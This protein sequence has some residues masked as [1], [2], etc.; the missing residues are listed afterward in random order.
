LKLTS[1]AGRL[2][3]APLLLFGSCRHSDGA[4]AR[5]TTAQLARAVEMLRLSS[6]HDKRLWLNRLRTLPCEGDDACQLQSVCVHAYDEHT[7][8]IDMIETAGHQLE[9]P[10][11]ADF[12]GPDA[13]AE[14]LLQTAA[15]AQRAQ[16]LLGQARRLTRNC[17]ENEAIIRERY[18]LR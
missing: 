2:W 1:G 12:G 4:E 11:D 18:R 3:L 13:S 17:A 14:A 8:A 10:P 9:P 5:A 15:L 7:K 6:N 16:R